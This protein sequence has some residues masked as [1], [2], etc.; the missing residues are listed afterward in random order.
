MQ[1]AHDYT[2]RT[3]GFLAPE[4]RLFFFAMIFYLV[5]KLSITIV[6]TSPFNQT[7]IFVNDRVLSHVRRT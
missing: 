4:I 6:F 1:V 3:K 5:T 7:C 2:W